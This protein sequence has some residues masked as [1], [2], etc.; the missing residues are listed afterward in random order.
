MLIQKLFL[1]MMMQTN[2]FT[3][4]VTI[5]NFSTLTIVMKM[6]RTHV[7]I[8]EERKIT[9]KWFITLNIITNLFIIAG[10]SRHWTPANFRDIHNNSPNQGL[11]WIDTNLN[12]TY[13]L[14]VG[15]TL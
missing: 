14:K 4:S 9:N 15:E 7:Y 2:M 13:N 12:T 1:H 11:K 3:T 5:W 10:V 6:K 8:L